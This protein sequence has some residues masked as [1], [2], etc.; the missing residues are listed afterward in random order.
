LR[1]AAPT[2]LPP[3]IAFLVQNGPFAGQGGPPQMLKEYDPEWGRAFWSGTVAASCDHE[4]MLSSVRVPVLLT[5]HIRMAYEETGG[6]RGA[7]SDVQAKRVR[8]LVTAAGQTIDYVSLPVMGHA[9]H[10]QD[11]AQFV[12]VL[13][14]WAAKLA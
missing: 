6:V 3:W 13:T 1:A 9:M 7:M 5:H 11:P 8:D 2:E 4:R 14:E 10:Q 12:K